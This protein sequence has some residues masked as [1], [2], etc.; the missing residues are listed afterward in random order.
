M[1]GAADDAG[2]AADAAVFLGGGGGGLEPAPATAAASL[3]L[4][5]EWPPCDWEEVVEEAA[6]SRISRW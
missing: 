6:A 3:R 4:E 1:P 5:V 2:V